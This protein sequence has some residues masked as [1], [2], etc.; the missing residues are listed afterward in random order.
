ML[1]KVCYIKY[2]YYNNKDKKNMY[3]YIHLLVV[4]IKFN[5]VKFKVIIILI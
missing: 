3:I 1:Y 4:N 5:I 2:I